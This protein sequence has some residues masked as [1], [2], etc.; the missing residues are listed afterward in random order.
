MTDAAVTA[1]CARLGSAHCNL[2]KALPVTDVGSGERRRRQRAN[3]CDEHAQSYTERVGQA[4]SIDQTSFGQISPATAQWTRVDNLTWP[5]TPRQRPANDMISFWIYISVFI[6]DVRLFGRG[7]QTCSPS[8]SQPYSG[9]RL[10]HDIDLT[11]L[12][13]VTYVALRHSAGPSQSV[14]DKFVR[15]VVGRS[16]GRPFP[17][18]PVRSLLS[19][20]VIGGRRQVPVTWSRDISDTRRISNGV[21]H[22]ATAALNAAMRLWC[23][24]SGEGELDAL[25]DVLVK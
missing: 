22:D 23:S 1:N 15:F 3:G 20:R 5:L 7:K 21:S 19:R 9:R 25:N 18:P 11:S 10:W 6:D 17:T 8:Y 24:L 12:S 14:A 2:H 13:D 4:A 16:A